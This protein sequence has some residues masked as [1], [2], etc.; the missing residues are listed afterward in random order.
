MKKF[1]YVNIILF[2]LTVITTLYAGAFQKG[3]DIFVEPLRFYEGWPFSL[4]LL[5]ILLAHEFSHYLTSRCHNTD[6]TLPYFLPAPTL[7]GTF[8]AIIKMK[9]P[10]LTRSA[11][12]DIGASGPI[13]GFLV[14]IIV[15]ITGLSYS[16]LEKTEN[17]DNMMSFGSS[18]IFSILVQL[19][20]GDV[21]DNYV[22]ILHPVGFAGWIGT[23]ITSLNLLPVGQ[24][25]GG[26]I[27]YALFGKKHRYVSL[28][29]MILLLIGGIFLWQGWLIW[30]LLLLIVGIK[31]PPVKNDKENLSR[32]RIITGILSFVIFLISFI[33]VPFDL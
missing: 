11:L 15:S 24:L 1:P 8:G 16:H 6:A 19:T 22:L 20:I 14:S 17:I 27:A 25:D 3:I 23:F 10:I 30:L 32:G 12:I 13:A 7:I 21:E 28:F 29:V 31:H 4:S 9:S 26:H 2:V 33:P 5:L 18:I